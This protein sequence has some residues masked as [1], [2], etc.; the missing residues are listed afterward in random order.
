MLTIRDRKMFEMLSMFKILKTEHIHKLCYPECKIDYVRQRLKL[1]YERKDINRN[2]EARHLEQSFIYYTG[3]NPPNQ[4]SHRLKLVDLYI[5]FNIYEI[6]TFATEYK[7]G[8]LRSDAYIEVVI[9]NNLH[10]FFIEIQRNS[11]LNY[12]K[13]E[14]LYKSGEY[15]KYGDDI[16]PKILIVIDSFLNLPESELTFI[17]L[18]NNLSNFKDILK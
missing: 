14:N 1:M 16:F 18:Q 2:Q 7:C 5:L 3:K 13:Y 12:N 17:Q 15:R 8:N 10:L 4:L 9:D 6:R 11:N